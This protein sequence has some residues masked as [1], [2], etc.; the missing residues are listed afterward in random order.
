MSYFDAREQVE[1]RKYATLKKGEQIKRYETKK[2][3][4]WDSE[5]K[6]KSGKPASSTNFIHADV[7]KV[8]GT[9]INKSKSV[10]DKKVDRSLSRNSFLD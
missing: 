5:M 2:G 6:E 7:Y 10:L 1:K 8:E 4:Y 9:L 3:Y